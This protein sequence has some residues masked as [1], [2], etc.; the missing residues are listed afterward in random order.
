MKVAKPGPVAPRRLWKDPIVMIC[1]GG[2]AIMLALLGGCLARVHLQGRSDEQ[3]VALGEW[4]NAVDYSG[5]E[6]DALVR[7]E[8]VISF[9]GGWRPRSLKALVALAAAEVRRKD[10]RYS[11]KL[12]EPPKLARSDPPGP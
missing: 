12:E 10:L 3:I 2:P 9:D 8:A 11:L 5:N 7:Y 1:W 6:K 4:A